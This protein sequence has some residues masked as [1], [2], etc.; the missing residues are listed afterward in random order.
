MRNLLLVLWLGA[1]MTACAS[2]RIGLTLCNLARAPD[3]TVAEAQAEV[4]YL[5]ELSRIEVEWRP[6]R[7][8]E[9]PD[10]EAT[11]ARFV[12]RIRTAEAP[13]GSEPREVIGRAYFASDS[14]RISAGT[15]HYADVYYAEAAKLAA[16]H[17]E[18]EEAEVLGCVVAHEI[19]HLLLGERHT[20][21]SLMAAT[22]NGEQAEAARKRGL[23]FTKR[24]RSEMAR[25]LRNLHRQETLLAKE[26]GADK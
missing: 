21:H 6:C 13:T 10:P 7:E 26:R 15:Y 22:W 14:P 18:A 17:S 2:E 4:S 16:S 1:A 19:G 3:R 11:Q 9:M 23:R 5:F 25:Q 12:V 20:P 24:D 8:M